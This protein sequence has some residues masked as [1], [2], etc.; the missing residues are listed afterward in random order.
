LKNIG[1]SE[2]SWQCQSKYHNQ[3]EKYH[4]DYLVVA[5]GIENRFDIIPG[6]IEALND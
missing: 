5:C 6:S 1:I 4:Y 2:K 3:N